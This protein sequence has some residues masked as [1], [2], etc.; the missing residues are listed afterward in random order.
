M[1]KQTKEYYDKL[2][3]RL[4]EKYPQIAEIS[5]E[6]DKYEDHGEIEYIHVVWVKLP[7]LLPFSGSA[8]AHIEEESDF[9]E[10]LSEI[11]LIERRDVYK[12]TSINFSNYGWDLERRGYNVLELEQTKSKEYRKNLWEIIQKIRKEENY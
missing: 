3:K 7:W 6:E 4:K 2:E 12:D 11:R 5:W 1:K 8:F 9:D 10:V